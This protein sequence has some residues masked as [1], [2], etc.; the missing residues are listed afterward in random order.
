MDTEIN[1]EHTTR[2]QPDKAS[3]PVRVRDNSSQRWSL[4]TNVTKTIIII[5]WEVITHC[6]ET[7]GKYE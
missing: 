2:N 3:E 1:V 7:N 5:M 4:E 6:L